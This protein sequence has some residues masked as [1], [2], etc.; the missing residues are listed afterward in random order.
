[1]NSADTYVQ[2]MP[3]Y[4]DTAPIGIVQ[5]PLHFD[6]PRPPL[7]ANGSYNRYQKARL[8]RDIRLATKLLA[9]RLPDLGRIEVS[10]TWYVKDHIRRDGGENMAPTLKPMIDGLVDAGVV[11]DDT[12]DLVV[13]GPSLVEYV[14]GCKPHMVLLVRRLDGGQN[15]E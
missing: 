5:F 6:Y 3:E 12:G 9:N 1:M 11:A 2:P 10:L 7:S 13:R 4:F 15:N 8:V 14:Q